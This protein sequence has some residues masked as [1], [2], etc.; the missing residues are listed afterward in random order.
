VRLCSERG[1]SGVE[2]FVYGRDG[3]APAKAGFPARQTLQACEAIIRSHGLDKMRT[4]L[5][6]QSEHAISSGAFHNDV[7]CVG[8]LNTLFYHE[9]AFENT[10][11]TKA[12]IN[13]AAQGLFEPVFKEVPAALVPIE[14]AISSYLFNSMLVQFPGDDRLTLIAPLETRENDNTRRYCEQLTGG[15]SS[16]GNVKFVD[17]RQSMRNGGGPA[18]LRLRVTLT[19][20]EWAKVSPAMKMD[21][22]L[23][24]KLSDWANKHYRDTLDPQ[25]LIDPSL[26]HESFAALDALTTILGL[27][28][29]FY[30]FQR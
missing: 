23:H 22:A 8:A 7:V 10:E 12:Q 21:Q 1:H 4:V 6:K 20:E 30:P 11:M 14:D 27:G 29:D 13:A 24:Q 16:I 5:A 9:Q 28:S 26:M 2:L 3:Y 17:V 25:D 18:C 19:S 15:N